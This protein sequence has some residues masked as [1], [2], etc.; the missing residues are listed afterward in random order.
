MK[1]YKITITFNA[2]EQK[3]ALVSRKGQLFKYLKT[4][5]WNTKNMDWNI[6]EIV[7]KKNK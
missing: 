7:V 6:E 1:N 5:F 2:H 4:F 3:E